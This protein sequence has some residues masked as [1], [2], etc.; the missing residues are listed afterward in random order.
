MRDI[1]LDLSMRCVKLN[2][3]RSLLAG[4]GIV[5]G[6]VAISS[7]GMLGADMQLSVK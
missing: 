1:F 7:M 4:I 3:F 6:V 2:F 5:I